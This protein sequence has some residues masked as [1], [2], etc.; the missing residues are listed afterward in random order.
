MSQTP[1][2]GQWTGKL[3]FILS[4]IG[5]SVGL[6]NIWRFPYLCYRNG[7][8]AFIIPYVIMLVIAGVPLYFLELSLGQFASQ[9]PVTV[10]NL[11]P[12]FYGIGWAMI[13]ISAMV[14]TYYNVI[15][16]YSV[17]YMLVSFVNLDDELPWQKCGKSWNTEK[18]R[19]EPYPDM[20]GMNE[21]SKVTA[22]LGLK[23]QSC[24]TDL[25]TAISGMY[26]QTYSTLTDLNS[27][28]LSEHTVDCDIKFQTP[29]AEYWNRYVLRVHESDGMEDIGGVSL[30]NVLCL[31]LCWIFIFFC[32]MKGVKS[33]GK[34]V[35]FTALFPY[36][37]LVV[38]LIRGLTLPGYEKGI[39][40]YIVPEWERLKDPKVWGDA[41]TQIFYSLGVAFGGILT[42]SSYNRFKNHT[43]R[44]ALI[45]SFVN[46]STSV[47]G[48]F[49]IFALLG[50]M[51]HVTNVPVEDVADSGPGLAFIAYPEGIAKLPSPPI[52]AFLFFFMIFTLGCDSQF[53][54]METV[55][56]G[57]S[58]VFPNQLRKR[59]TLFTFFC[60][61][62]GFLLGIPQATKG[63]IYILTLVDWYSGSYNLMIICFCEIVAVCYIYGVNKFRADV[64]MM[65]GKQS[66]IVWSYFYATWC[67]ITPAAI[68]FI[69]IM[70]AINYSPAYLGNYNY[71]G[72]AEA[73]GWFM[74]VTPLLLVLGGAIVQSIRSGGVGIA[75][76][77]VREWGPALDEN[78][79]PPRYASLSDPRHD[80]IQYNSKGGTVF[81]VNKGQDNK[82]YTGEKL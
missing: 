62:I 41:A 31:L 45:I 14:C 56:S 74:V 55:I 47:F 60:C 4:C 71:P 15:I 5:F 52:F 16:M 50:Y 1:E 72:F 65:I 13:M 59:K 78:R 35:Y 22:M 8:G 66:I 33:S 76:R 51:S 37:V 12:I 82:S 20:D 32:L 30:K 26:N 34:V 21:T 29:S 25:L 58:D 23:D 38:L 17:Y 54:M 61:M 80:D 40:F 19:D 11:C 6:G 68:A 70:M 57:F 43:L 46:C 39:K 28:H 77:P 27:T 69:V 48:G 2:R 42:M 49:A 3:D 7:G 67:F 9:G 79:I 53:A 36:V 64:E 81:V 44:D 24:L 73:L 18:C 63:G 75:L 10:W